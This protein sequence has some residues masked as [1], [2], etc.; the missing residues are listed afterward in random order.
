MCIDH[1]AKGLHISNFCCR[2]VAD[3]PIEKDGW[4]W[5]ELSLDGS[6]TT[7]FTI[8]VNQQPLDALHYGSRT[9]SA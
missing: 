2:L 9:P 8:R 5:I 4:R 7:S 3:V 1:R 6:P